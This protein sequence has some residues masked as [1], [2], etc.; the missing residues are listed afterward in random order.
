LYVKGEP[1][2]TPVIMFSRVSALVWIFSLVK[3][4]NLILHPLINLVAVDNYN[5]ATF[6][7]VI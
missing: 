4:F 2:P 5:E 6:L 7:F 1:L 3:I